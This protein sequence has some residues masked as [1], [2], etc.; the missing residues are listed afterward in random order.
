MTIDPNLLGKLLDIFNKIN[1][2]KQNKELTI[3]EFE[4]GLREVDEIMKSAPVSPPAKEGKENYEQDLKRAKELR[5]NMRMDFVPFGKK[6]EFYNELCRLGIKLN[7]TGA[8][9]RIIED[10][11]KFNAAI[12]ALLPDRA[13]Q[14][15]EPI[16]PLTSIKSL[17]RY[18]GS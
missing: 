11:M 18:Y 4:K 2:K 17:E 9:A 13:L 3:D 16:D 6:T 10:I 5:E 12:D 1:K 15:L 7:E 14:K 8:T